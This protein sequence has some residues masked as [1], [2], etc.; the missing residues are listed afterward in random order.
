[1]WLRQAKRQRLHHAD[2]IE[3]QFVDALIAAARCVAFSERK[4]GD[5]KLAQ[6]RRDLHNLT[7]GGQICPGKRIDK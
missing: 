4:G 6:Q 3:D 1:L 5:D 7:G 2:F